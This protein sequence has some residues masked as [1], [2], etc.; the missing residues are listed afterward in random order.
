MIYTIS[1]YIMAGFYVLAGI[2]HFVN[3]GFYMSIMPKW[4]PMHQ[5]M[6]SLSGVVEIVLG[7][8]LIPG[9]TRS[10]A[11]WL[12][13]AMLTVFFIVHFDMLWVYYKTGHK[14]L[15]V[16]IVRIPIQFVLIWWA[17]KYTK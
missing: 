3:P 13:I 6:V 9:M 2:N 1:L 4:F 8:M 15:W 10:Y 7:L 12:V 17:W 16:A 14:L 11:A 5:A